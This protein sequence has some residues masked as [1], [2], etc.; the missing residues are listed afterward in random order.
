MDDRLVTCGELA[1][2]IEQALA[3]THDAA[4][5]DRIAV[6]HYHDQAMEEA[7]RELVRMV[8]HNADGD[9]TRVSEGDRKAHM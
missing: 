6:N 4:S 2:L 1:T 7:R 9:P 5:W 3:G 8:G